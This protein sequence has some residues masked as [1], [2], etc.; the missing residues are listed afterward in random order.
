MGEAR[1]MEVFCRSLGRWVLAEETESKSRGVRTVFFN[2]D[3]RGVCRKQI[4]EDSASLRPLARPSTKPRGTFQ[5][6]AE[7]EEDEDPEQSRW[8]EDQSRV[9]SWEPKELAQFLKQAAALGATHNGEAA[10]N[11]PDQEKGRFKRFTVYKKGSLVEQVQQVRE[12]VLCFLLD[13]AESGWWRNVYSFLSKC[14]QS[15]SARPASRQYGFLDL[16]ASQGSLVAV[17]KLLQLGAEVATT[18]GCGR[19][20]LQVALK[21]GQAKVAAYLKEVEDHMHASPRSRDK[22]SANLQKIGFETKGPMVFKRTSGTLYEAQTDAAFSTFSKISTTD[23]WDAHATSCQAGVTA[24]EVQAR[25]CNGPLCF[26]LSSNPED[27]HDFIDGFG[28]LFGQVHVPGLHKKPKTTS[29]RVVVDDVGVEDTLKMSVED[30]QV[31]VYINDDLLHTFPPR[32]GQAL[33]AKVFIFKESDAL[34]AGIK[35]FVSIPKQMQLSMSLRS[36][37]FQVMLRGVLMKL[38][39]NW[40]RQEVEDDNDPEDRTG[41]MMYFAS[42]VVSLTTRCWT[43]EELR[44]MD[45]VERK[46]NLVAFNYEWTT[47]LWKAIKKVWN[48]GGVP[49]FSNLRAKFHTKIPGSCKNK[50]VLALAFVNV[51]KPEHR[52]VAWTCWRQRTEQEARDRFPHKAL[53]TVC[54][55]QLHC[56]CCHKETSLWFDVIRF[57]DRDPFHA[58]PHDLPDPDLLQQPHSSN[59]HLQKHTEWMQKEAGPGGRGGYSCPMTLPGSVPEKLAAHG[60]VGEYEGDGE[61]EEEEEDSGDV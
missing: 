38:M 11:H 33:Y 59:F 53:H 5:V 45:D 27:S 24:V 9:S 47:D 31:K 56:V 14:P 51:L 28:V 3:G 57:W 29:H 15:V 32:E 2:I 21:H 23:A 34:M 4:R 43:A 1:K 54:F 39:P 37:D 20:P 55:A 35:P 12:E 8:M 46:N 17:K 10:S 42:L 6:Q 22:L 58:R 18:T 52:W 44:D 36:P 13:L 16:A 61:E 40:L 48:D 30:S 60:V 41:H 26:G 19:S 50:A 25:Q 7:Q 49:K